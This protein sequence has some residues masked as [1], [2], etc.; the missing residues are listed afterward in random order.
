MAKEK[1]VLSGMRPTGDL[2]LGHWVGAL[3]N[4]VRLQ[5]KYECFFMVADWHA[6]MSEYKNY[7]SMRDFIFSNVVDWLSCGVSP[8]KSV[9][10]LQSQVRA[11]LD[12][13]MLFSILTPLGWLERCPT[14]KEMLQNLKERQIQTHAFIGYPVLQAADILIYKAE[15][16]PVGEDQ[17][18]HLELAREIVRR[19]NFHFGLKLP[20]PQPLLT[21]VPRLVG[22]D[23]RKMSKSYG[24]VISLSDDEKTVSKKVSSMITD[25]NRIRKTDPG[26]PSVCSVFSYHK[27]FSLEDEVSEIESACKE[28]KIG[29]VEC[30]RRLS[31]RLNELLSPIREKRN[32]F[33]SHKDEVWGIL[34]EGGKKAKSVAE[35]VWDEIRQ[36]IWGRL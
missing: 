28:G 12:L 8:E 29:C 16:V 3:N 1:R 34:Q 14:Y 30:K 9:V 21:Q 31:C 22:L 10:F 15:V 36:R 20:E 23:G 33:I 4:W 27:V 26:T 11:H 24:N 19:A 17:L 35:S 13:Y 2:H 5:D 32:Y 25:P 18:P 7:G 6:L